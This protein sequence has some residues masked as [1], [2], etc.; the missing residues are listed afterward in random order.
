MH[1]GHAKAIHNTQKLGH[2]G[3][4]RILMAGFKLRLLLQ[5]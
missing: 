5:E 4:R 2:V 1:L 3:I